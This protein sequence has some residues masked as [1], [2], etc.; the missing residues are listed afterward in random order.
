M[1]NCDCRHFARH[2]TQVSPNNWN[3]DEGI[4]RE[5]MTRVMVLAEWNSEYYYM[6]FNEWI[7]RE[8]T[9]SD[10]EELFHECVGCMCC[11]RHTINRPIVL[12]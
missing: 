8:L 9:K 12:D 1:C 6:S 5:N 11:N 4:E 7:S 3:G 2:L 10:A